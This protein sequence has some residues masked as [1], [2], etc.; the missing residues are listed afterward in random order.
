MEKQELIEHF[1]AESPKAQ[2]RT[3]ETK[4]KIM[5]CS[6]ELFTKVGYGSTTIRDIAAQ[7]DVKNQVIGYHFGSKQD[8]WM[9]CIWVLSLDAHRRNSMLVIDPEAPRE[10]FKKH[11]IRVIKNNIAHPQL[12]RMIFHEAIVNSPQCEL[13]KGQM[14]AFSEGIQSELKKGIDLGIIKDVPLTDLYFIY[15][16]AINARFMTPKA[17]ELISGL[18]ND[19]EGMI[20][21][22]ANTLAE[23]LFV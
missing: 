7:A 13:L 15:I 14:V 18:P 1:R 11:V 23:V 8:L 19:H 17:N 3:L 6:I 22:H 4:A 20:E 21:S 10:S 16:N 2:A 12:N 5:A 9:T